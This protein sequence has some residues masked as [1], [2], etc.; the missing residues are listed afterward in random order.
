MPN[1]LVTG[2]HAFLTN[3]ALSNIANTTIFNLDC[4]SNNKKNNNELN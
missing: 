4:W 3:E 2:H 1:V